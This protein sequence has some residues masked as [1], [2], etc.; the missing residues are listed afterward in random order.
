MKCAWKKVL[1]RARIADVSA[2]MIDCLVN[3]AAYT[4]RIHAKFGE[5]RIA[6][7]L[8]SASNLMNET[9]A[10]YAEDERE[11]D[12]RVLTAAGSMSAELKCCGFDFRAMKN[13]IVYH[14][15]FFDTY[16]YKR[17]KEK[18]ERRLEYVKIFDLAQ[19]PIHLSFL[20]AARQEYKYGAE[21]LGK[22]YAAIRADSDP[23]FVEYLRCTDKGDEKI[24]EMLK[25]KQDVLAKCGIQIR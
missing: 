18:H 14:D 5:E 20:Q 25:E 19:T 23:F 9:I 1:A 15:P 22:F 3:S 4:A 6:R 2:Q 16:R 12:E 17:E 24:L 7:L 8:V 13:Q 10:D 21:R 11:E